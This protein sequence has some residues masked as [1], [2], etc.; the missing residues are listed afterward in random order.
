MSLANYKG[1]AL[2][3]GGSTSNDCA[4]RTEIYNFEAGRWID[5]P[6]YPFAS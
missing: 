1:Q 4:T 5:G 2:T 3:T 6:N